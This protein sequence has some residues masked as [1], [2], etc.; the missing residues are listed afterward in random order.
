[1]LLIVE[2]INVIGVIFLHGYKSQPSSVAGRRH[3]WEMIPSEKSLRHFHFHAQT[4]T[5]KKRLV[6][7]LIVCGCLK[8]VLLQMVGSLGIFYRQMD[9]AILKL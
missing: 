3:A 1:M 4:E 6:A 8:T 7:V 9:E 5:E 2:I